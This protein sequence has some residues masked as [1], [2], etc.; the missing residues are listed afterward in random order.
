MPGSLMSS[1]HVLGSGAVIRKDEKDILA[2]QKNSET[3][4]VVAQF[5]LGPG[6]IEELQHEL[7]GEKQT[8]ND[9]QSFSEE[10]LE[11]KEQMQSDLQ[12]LTVDRSRQALQIEKL[13]HDLECGKQTI[14][15]L[16]SFSEELL[17]EKEEMHS[18][19]KT[20][21]VDMARQIQVLQKEKDNL[22]RSMLLLQV[23]S[24]GSSE[25]CTREIEEE[26]KVLQQMVTET[27]HKLSKLE[28]EKQSLQRDME[29]MQERVKQVE[30]LEEKLHQLETENTKLAQDFTS[31]T[32]TTTKKIDALER[33]NQGLSLENQQ[34]SKSL[35]TLHDMSVQLKGLEQNNMQLNEENLELRRMVET[36]CCMRANMAPIKMENQELEQDDNSHRNAHKDMLKPEAEQEEMETVLNTGCEAQQQE[37]RTNAIAKRE[38]QRLRDELDRVNFLTQ[39]LK[40]EREELHTHIKVLE[41]SLHHSQLELND[42]QAQF[43]QLKEQH[44][45]LDYHCELLSC[46]KE[47]LED[48]NCHLKGKI[49]MLNQQNQE[50]LEKNTQSKEQYH[51]EQEQSMNQL[52]ALQRNTEKP[53]EKAREQDESCSPALKKKH[54]WIGA[55]AFINFIQQKKEGGRE[56]PKSAS[57]GTSWPLESSDHTMPSTSQ[58][59]ESQLEHL[60]ATPSCS[61]WGEE[62]D[63]PKVPSGKAPSLL[64]STAPFATGSENVKASGA[65]AVLQPRVPLEPGPSTASQ[66]QHLRGSHC[67]P[68]PRLAPATLGLPSPCTSRPFPHS[69]TILSPAPFLHTGPEG[70]ECPGAALGEAGLGL[71]AQGS[72]WLPPAEGN[73]GLQQVGLPNIS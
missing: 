38:N 17:E 13:Q 46:L 7:E 30:E 61:K 48:K 60:E 35:A 72:Q 62:Q 22:N 70:G 68:C 64:A 2:L 42:W 9:L 15:D 55:K 3:W 4:Q 27:S 18:D 39:Q 33:E 26:N 31:L 45:S 21:R 12:T 41:S 59:P 34:L 23:T 43:D 40:G 10:L 53:E 16:Q 47:N 50:L 66:L 36:M 51:E 63:T 44:Q 69:G 11:E 24:L 6:W 67:A 25:A 71:A 54:H 52:N 5:A 14:N 32:L 56:H 73:T 28:C 8:I 58:P 37:Q 20:V 65:A 19:L 49:N 29:Q 1:G 57:D